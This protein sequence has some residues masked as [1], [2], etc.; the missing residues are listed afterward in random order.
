MLDQMVSVFASG[1]AFTT[2]I[3][4]AA[5]GE[6]F[7]ERAGVI[8]LA[9]E[10]EILAA[11]FCSF[12][13]VSS[14]GNYFLGLMAGVAA[15]A[16]IALIHAFA[17]VTLSV[18]QIVSGIGLNMIVFAGT[19]FFFRQIFWGEEVVTS[20]PNL[21][22]LDN[23]PL[24]LLSQIPILG[25]ILFDHNILTYI[26]ILTV[27]LASFVL[28]KTNYGLAIR[29]SGEDPD[30]VNSAGINSATVRYV[31]VIL[32]G[33][34]AG[35]GGVSLSMGETGIFM[36]GMSAGRGFLAVSAVIFGNWR[37]GKVFL[38]AMLFGLLSSLQTYLQAVG[39]PIPHQFMQMMPYIICI[40][41]LAAATRKATVP[42]S[43][44]IPFRR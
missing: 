12:I 17:S 24:P 6:N 41:A 37:P 18:D 19:S 42:A 2:P 33:V 28:Y 20:L 21:S 22:I 30:S 27:P 4:L 43:L 31:S 39:A 25:P 16:L 10:G 26:A 15:A 32:G 35:L 13:V 5:I 9:V 14:T 11:A 36:D 44:G 7:S 34:L 29:A 38:G 1:I 40:L 23:I 8:V 3:L